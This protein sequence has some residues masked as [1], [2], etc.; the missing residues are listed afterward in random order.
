[1]MVLIIDDLRTGGTA[2]AAA[3]IIEMSNGNVSGFIFVIIFLIWVD[4][5]F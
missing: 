1:M 3:K 2:E 4:V 5:I